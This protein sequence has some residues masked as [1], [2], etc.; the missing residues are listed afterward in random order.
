MAQRHYG[1]DT[2]WRRDETS[3]RRDIM[4]QRHHCDLPFW[5]YSLLVLLEGVSR[6]YIKYVALT[7]AIFVIVREAVF[8]RLFN[9]CI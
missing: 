4:A 6:G 1:Q 3:F 9:S 2:L 8:I 7:L 5:V